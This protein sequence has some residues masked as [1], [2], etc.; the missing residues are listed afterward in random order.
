MKADLLI[1]NIGELVT[2]ASQGPKKGPEMANPGIH[3]NA[4]VAVVDGRF[5]TVGDSDTVLRLHDADEVIDA[6]GRV[7]MPG[8]VECHTHIVYAGDRLDE[9]ELRIKGAE[10]MEILEAGGGI[11]S[12]VRATREASVDELVELSG[13]RLD[14]LL[15]NGVTT[16]EIKTGYGLD[17]ET[18][19]K[20]LEAIVRLGD[21]HPVDVVPTFLPAHAV[22]PEYRNGAKGTPDD[23]V[24]M[25][26]DEMIPK[27]AKWFSDAGGETIFIDVFCE[28]NAFDLEQTRK[29]LEA[30]KKAGFAIKA[31][32]D[33]FTNLGGAELA[34]SLGAASVDH[35]DAISDREIGL[36]AK[37]ATVGVV[38]PTVN[39][40]LGSDEFADARKLI[41]SGCAVALSTDYNP[42]SAPCPSPSIAMAI[43]CRYQKLLPAESINGFT[44]NAAHAVGKGTEAG[45]IEIGKRADLLILDTRDHRE[46][47]YE[48]GGNL[49]EAV[50]KDGIPV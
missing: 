1:H 33:E 5:H 42:G 3:R 39:F 21:E 32:V 6:E 22:P 50:F 46:I 48:F 41:D 14:R 47:C 17:T 10:Y 35:L 34:I 26:C 23:Y 29:V 13:V 2:C 9:F 31:H 44:I 45:S 16:C 30:A 8:F 19:M 37:S 18:E 15:R 20:M 25:I 4:G 36:L 27:A 28:K 38:T 24:A 43:A 7:V 49:V 11:L 12:T 40:N